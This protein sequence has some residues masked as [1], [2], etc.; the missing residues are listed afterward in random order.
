MIT[1]PL[2]GIVDIIVLCSILSLL[3]KNFHIHY[4]Q[5]YWAGKPS[6]E[7]TSCQ[8]HMCSGLSHVK[9]QPA[10]SLAVAPWAVT[11]HLHSSEHLYCPGMRLS[12]DDGEL[13]H[14]LLPPP[15]P[16]SLPLQGGAAS[17]KSHGPL[18]LL[19]MPP[20]S[21]CRPPF[22]WKLAPPLCFQHFTQFL[23][24]PSFIFFLLFH[25]FTRICK[26]KSQWLNQLWWEILIM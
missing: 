7:L 9:W 18:T 15:Y 25:L 3:C 13:P 23:F 1:F 14:L 8:A 26:R 20:L 11:H 19:K 2:K 4:N 21:R 6:T 5:L 10:H 17:Y 16:S 24:S 12:P 22:S